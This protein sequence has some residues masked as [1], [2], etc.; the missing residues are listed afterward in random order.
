MINDAQDV[1]TMKKYL[2]F[3]SNTLKH[4]EAQRTTTS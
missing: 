2:K 1:V 4:S 3:H